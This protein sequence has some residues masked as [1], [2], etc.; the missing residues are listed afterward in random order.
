MKIAL[1]ITTI[2]LIFS[3]FIRQAIKNLGDT[4]PKELIDNYNFYNVI[5]NINGIALVSSIIAEVI[6]LV[7]LLL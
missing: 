1:I 3:C 5:A 2:I 6:L 4:N 7:L